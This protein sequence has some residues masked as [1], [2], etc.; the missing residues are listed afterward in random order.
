M[1]IRNRGPLDGLTHR[2]MT[3]SVIAMASR[4]DQSKAL[5]SDARLKILQWL[6]AP[7]AHFAEQRSGDPARIG[8][9]VTLIAER[10]GMSQPTISRHLEIL[11]RAGFARVR[12]IGRW[13]FF[14]RDE[15]GIDD[16]RRWLGDAL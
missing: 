2:Y 15:A 10:L 4:A 5:A 6:R 13:S 7:G 8:V 3:I 14:S 16:Y 1:P 9:C 11:H 12:R